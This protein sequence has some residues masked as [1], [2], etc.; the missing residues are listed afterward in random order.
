[1]TA[2]KINAALRS[3]WPSSTLKRQGKL[4]FTPNVIPIS[5]ATRWT[6]TRTM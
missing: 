5:T 4:M 3:G 2:N 6:A 1:M